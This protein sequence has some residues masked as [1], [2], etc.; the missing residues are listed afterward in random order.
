MSYNRINYLTR[1]IEVQDTVKEIRKNTGM[2]YKEI[3][4]RYIK[5]QWRISYSSFN[6]YLSVPSPKTQLEKEFIKM[7]NQDN[8]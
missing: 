1:V 7:E 4:R 8:G 6:N 3:Y 5:K 2:F